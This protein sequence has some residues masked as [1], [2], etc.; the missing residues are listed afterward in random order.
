MLGGKFLPHKWIGRFK[1]T[2]KTGKIRWVEGM[3]VKKRLVHQAPTRF[4]SEY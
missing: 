3:E 4:R 1:E 2:K